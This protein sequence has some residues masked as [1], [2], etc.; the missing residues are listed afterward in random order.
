MSPVAIQFNEKRAVGRP[1]NDSRIARVSQP[2]WLSATTMDGAG[3]IPRQSIGGYGGSATHMLSIENLVALAAYEPARATMLLADTIPEVSK[4]VW[5]ALRLGCG[6]GAVTY[7]AMKKGRNGISQE[8]APE[9]TEAL[10]QLYSTLPKEV[11][12]FTDALAQNFLMTDF[13]GMCAVEGVPGP[14]GKGLSELWPLDTLTLKFRRNKADRR[15]YLW[16]K[17]QSSRDIPQGRPIYNGYQ[18]LP[19]D[20]V[21]WSSLDGFPDNPYGRAPK[22]GILMPVFE[23]MAYMK[24]LLLAWHRVGT[25]KWDI[26]F[27]YEM[28]AIIAREQLGLADKNEIT[29]FIEAQFLRA[30][31]IFEQL[32][33]DDAFFHDIKSKVGVNGSGGAWPNINDI[34]N[35]LRWRL[36][37]ALHEMPTMMGVV[38]GST[39]TWSSVDWQVYAKGMEVGVVKAATPILDAGQLHLQL[40][41]MPYII[42]AEYAPIRAN[43]RMVDAQSEQLEIENEIKKE[44][45]GYQ[46]HDEGSIR[47]TGTVAVAELDKEALKLVPPPKNTE[48]KSPQGPSKGT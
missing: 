38:E 36:M 34:W 33:A 9:G 29:A 7:R 11:G 44:L 15:L 26:G 22:A 12:T 37:M 1:R 45:A 46:T 35:L 21:F 19:P 27:D 30:V 6:K 48:G 14:R 8:E 41:G 25:P 10:K 23:I 43:Q 20:R 42:E 24:D 31:E 16:Q 47:I 3:F 5:N 40:M 32:N 17:V 4:S 2:S 18:Q 39:E 13:T 28:W